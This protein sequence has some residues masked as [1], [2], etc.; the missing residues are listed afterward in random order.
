[1]DFGSMKKRLLLANFGYGVFDISFLFLLLVGF[2]ACSTS[3]SKTVT[4]FSPPPPNSS[5]ELTAPRVVSAM[6]ALSRGVAAV[7]PSG[8]ALQDVYYEFDSV[9]LLSDAEEIL[10]KNA[11]WMKTHPSAQVEVEGHCDDIGSAEYN[12]ALG[13]KRAQAAKQFLVDQGISSDR[14]VTI[15]YGKEAP[16][17]FELTEE[18]R[19]KNRRAR[20]V[21]FKELPTS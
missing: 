20:F 3:D 14:L 10:K 7:T 2:S 15:S 8:A 9:D 6:E 17:C 12:L 4:L 5:A 16:A 21:I 13:A 1:V 19:V 18:C 11:E